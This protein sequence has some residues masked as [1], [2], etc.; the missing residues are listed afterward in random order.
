M[1]EGRKNK[2]KKY[3]KS[4]LAEPVYRF[5]SPELQQMDRSQGSFFFLTERFGS[6]FG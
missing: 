2:K 3:L 1:P 5:Q 4:N 6:K